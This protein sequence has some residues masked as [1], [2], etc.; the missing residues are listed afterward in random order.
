MTAP[1]DRP[2]TSALDA[3][4]SVVENVDVENA[5]VDALAEAGYSIVRMSP[6]MAAPE[7]TP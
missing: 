3:I 2:D 5:I 7:D 1:E 4:D 6:P